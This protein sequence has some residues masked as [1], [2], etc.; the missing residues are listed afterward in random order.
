MKSAAIYARVST[1]EQRPETQ[2]KELRAYAKLRNVRVAHELVDFENGAKDKLL[3]VVRKRQVD[4]VP[5]WKLDR[6]ARST[7]QLLNALE[8]FHELG[9][10][11]ISYTEYVDASPARD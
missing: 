6:F 10:D 4:I 1:R 3:D 5:V 2:L 7:K 8:E 9:V 11:F